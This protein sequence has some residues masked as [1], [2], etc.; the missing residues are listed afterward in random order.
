MRALPFERKPPRAAGEH[1]SR[2]RACRSS[3]MPL[4]RYDTY[5]HMGWGAKFQ[6]YAALELG[7]WL[8]GLFAL[9]WRFQPAIRFV[10]TQTGLRTVQWMGGWLQRWVPSQ[11][12]KVARLSS[13]V[14]TSDKGRTT[15]EWLLLNKVLAPVALPSKIFLANY[16]VNKYSQQQLLAASEVQVLAPA[17]AG[18]V[19][20]R[21]R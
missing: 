8:P 9:C 11:Y 6:A 12:E 10:Q 14:Y 7:L 13:R 21:P 1:T 19:P 15:A 17:T 2:V 18:P 3:R 20:L 16:I 4:A 5:G